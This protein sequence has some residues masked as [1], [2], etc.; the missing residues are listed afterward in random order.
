MALATVTE[1]NTIGMP[2]LRLVRLT[3][4]GTTSTYLP[5]V[6]TGDVVGVIATNESDSDGVGIGVSGQTITI[7]VGTSGDVVTLLIAGRK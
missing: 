5:T 7:T 3:T 6:G 4:T 2:G 1:E